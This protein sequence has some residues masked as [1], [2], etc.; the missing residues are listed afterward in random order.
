[1]TIIQNAATGAVIRAALDAN[2]KPEEH[3]GLKFPHDKHLKPEGIRDPDKGMVKL[4]C[5]SCHK[6]DPG[7]VSFIPIRMTV[8]CQG[9]HALRFDA[10]ALDRQL[11]H[12]NA[13]EAQKVIADFYAALALRGEVQDES[14]PDVVRRRP[15]E[16][17][18]EAERKQALAW[19]DAKAS[20]QAD[21][22]IGKTLCGSCHTVAKQADGQWQV[23]PVKLQEHWLPNARFV[24]NKHASVNCDVCHAARKS[25]AATDVLLPGVETCQACH[26][27]EKSAAKV[28]STCITCHVFHNP[29]QPPFGNRRSADAGGMKQARE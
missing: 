12:G 24:H 2:P 22:V 4:D 29:G 26:G 11:P 10:R 8:D 1:P 28:P 25:D 27:G 18:P 5:A 15:G 19:A 9:C 6:P 17:L 3:S 21:V 16:P 20:E 23:A 14:A 7:G 13:A